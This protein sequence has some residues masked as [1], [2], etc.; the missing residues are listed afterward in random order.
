[1]LGWEDLQSLP[2]LLS[3]LSAS[4]EFDRL[5]DIIGFFLK[6]LLENLEKVN[7]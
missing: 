4:G 5:L 3:S 6:D 1:M 7:L 2:E